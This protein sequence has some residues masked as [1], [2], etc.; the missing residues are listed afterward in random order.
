MTGQTTK[1]SAALIGCGR[2]GCSTS[3]RLRRTLP[4]GWLPLSHAD[5]M[6]ANRDQMELLALCD[7]DAERLQAAA[8]RY[9]VTRC[10]SD[11][12][13]LI[14]E[15]KPDVLAV[16][17]RCRE[18]TAIVEYAVESGV[19]GIHAEK[20]FSR[21]LSDCRRALKAVE[22]NGACL[23]Y[24]TTRRWMDAYRQARA[25][26]QQGAIGELQEIA[27]EFGRAPLLWSHPHA[28]D[29]LLFLN[30]S[31]E[32]DFVQANCRMKANDPD[33]MLVDE[34]PLVEFAFIRF[35]NG[36]NALISSGGGMNVRVAGS[37]GTLTIR[38]DG[39]RVELR[40]RHRDDTPYYRD[41]ES[42]SVFARKSGT[43]RCF[44][45]LA[46][47][48]RG[49]ATPPF[50]PDDIERGQ[51]ILFAIPLSSLQGGRR[52]GLEEVPESFTVSGR[53]GNLYA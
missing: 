36:V 5:A 45:E 6:I 17:T 16:A 52:V 40:T 48:V 24:G 2:I 31:T 38:E 29:T 42:L 35:T 46:Q 28:V 25:L 22:R 26:L 27:I 44:A 10:F 12:R 49:G 37:S 4:P 19:R 43:E 39:A 51:Q 3:E 50:T 33:T 47:A 41:A 11:Y 7:V 14:D 34:D 21:N 18:R 15:L 53:S 8:D 9:G 23:S 32:V 1:L 13:S 20:P 30:G